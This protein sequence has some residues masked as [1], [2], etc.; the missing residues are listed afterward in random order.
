M[1]KNKSPGKFSALHLTCSDQQFGMCP[2]RQL[3]V[4][5]QYA[6]LGLSLAVPGGG[7]KKKSPITSQGKV[8]GPAV[9]ASH[10]N[11]DDDEY[12]GGLC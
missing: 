3:L 11:E 4:F 8:G 12:A 6:K 10:G 7:K 1:E 9:A 5:C 2:K